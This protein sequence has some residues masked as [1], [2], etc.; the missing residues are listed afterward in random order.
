MFARVVVQVVGGELSLFA[1]SSTML[2]TH[3]G[4]AIKGTAVLP[5]Y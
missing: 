4:I 5:Y 2:R 1:C 3:G